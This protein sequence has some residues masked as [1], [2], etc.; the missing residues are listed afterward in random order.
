MRPHKMPLLTLALT[1]VL[2][3]AASALD[4]QWQPHD[5]QAAMA[6]ARQEGKLLYIFVEGNNCPP[7]DSFKFSHLGDP[8]YADFINTLFVPLKMHDGN[9][10][11]RA[12]L[13]SLRLT[14]GAVPRFYTLTPEGRG[15]SMSIGTVSAA[16]MGAV[17]VLRMATGHQLPINQAAAAQ[18]AARI[19][20]YAHNERAAGRLYS[21][22]TM[23]NFGVAAVE[24]W[25]WAL[26]GRLDEAERAWGP[27]WLN[28]L[29]DQD[30][31]Q[32]Y[33]TFWA[34]WGRNTQAALKAATD[35]RN[36]SPAD[37]AANYLVAIALAANG[38]Y[39]EAITIAEPLLASN[40]T[41]TTLANDLSHWKSLAGM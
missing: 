39:S 13:G 8:V 28:Q 21:D 25:A 31:R 12:L 35:F 24:A 20:A 5:I 10:E 26:A 18:L 34:K 37:P 7:C 27:E 33:V 32:A 9:P 30:L 4:V 41:N 19:R 6:K 3:T 2:T 29:N 22:G 15:V 11:D 23:R 40:P 36:T 17:E 16:P 14:H 38:R 1:L